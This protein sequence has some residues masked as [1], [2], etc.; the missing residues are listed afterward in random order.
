M[1][2]SVGPLYSEHK[3]LDEDSLRNLAR[4]ETSKSEVRLSEL[5]HVP[6]EASRVAGPSLREYIPTAAGLENVPE[7]LL[8]DYFLRSLSYEFEPSLTETPRLLRTRGDCVG[9]KGATTSRLDEIVYEMRAE[10]W[11][12]EAYESYRW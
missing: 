2:L 7:V 6:T 3:V 8:K 1:T 4:G 12:L 9:L 11:T 10:G 5:E